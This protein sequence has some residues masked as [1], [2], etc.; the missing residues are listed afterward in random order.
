MKFGEVP[1]AEAA[2]AILAHSLKLGTTALKKGRVLSPADVELI[3]AA[4]LSAIVVARLEPGDVGE[5]DAA[6]RVAAAAVGPGISAAAPFTGRANLHAEARGLLVFERERVDRLNLVDEAVTLGTLP[7][8]TVV[9]PRQM[10]ATVKIIPFAAARAGGRT[11]RR[12]RPIGG[13]PAAAGRAVPAALGR[14]DPDPAAGPQGEHPR[15]DPRGDRGAGSP[16][17]AARSCSRRAAP[18]DRRARRRMIRAALG[19]RRSTCC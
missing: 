18:I 9:E 13:R 11:L 12:R 15:Q 6:R 2:G 17:S 14:A 3:A 10:V 1:V 5:D 16:H 19:H 7:P 8:F 4:G